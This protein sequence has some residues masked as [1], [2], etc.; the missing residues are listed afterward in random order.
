MSP[1][2]YAI[3]LPFSFFFQILSSIQKSEAT[4]EASQ[5]EKPP[6]EDLEALETR[7]RS[8][9]DR[10]MGNY[11]ERQY[12]RVSTDLPITFQ[13]PRYES[14]DY[15]S[16]KHNQR[17]DPDRRTFFEDFGY[18]PYE[19]R[20]PPHSYPSMSGFYQL[21]SSIFGGGD[22]RKPHPPPDPY[23]FHHHYSKGVHE[24]YPYEFSYNNNYRPTESNIIPPPKPVRASVVKLESVTPEPDIYPALDFTTTAKYYPHFLNL[25]HQVLIENAK[26]HHTNELGFHQS[27]PDPDPYINFRQ[28]PVLDRPKI[29]NKP[30]P[31]PKE[32]IIPTTYKPIA[33]YHP[34][35]NHTRP[36]Y[37]GSIQDQLPPLKPGDDNR[38]PYVSA[39]TIKLPSTTEKSPETTTIIDPRLGATDNIVFPTAEINT[40][41]DVLSDIDIRILNANFNSIPSKIVE[42]PSP[43][44]NP[45]TTTTPKIKYDERTDAILAGEST[46]TYRITVP[47]PKKSSRSKKV[48]PPRLN[49]SVELITDLT[50][51]GLSNRNENVNI[52]RYVNHYNMSNL[53]NYEIDKLRHNQPI[54]PRTQSQEISTTDQSLTETPPPPRHIVDINDELSLDVKILKDT[55]WDG[56]TATDPPTTE[57]EVTQK[58]P[59]TTTIPET[60]TIVVETRV[61]KSVSK[62]VGFSKNHIHQNEV[63]GKDDIAITEPTKF[64]NFD[65]LKENRRKFYNRRPQIRLS[66]DD[67]LREITT[68]ER[69]IPSTEAPTTNIVTT[70]RSTKLYPVITEPEM[71]FTTAMD[72]QKITTENN[73]VDSLKKRMDKPN[74]D[75]S[76]DIAAMITKPTE[77]T[78]NR[79]RKYMRR[80]KI[81][82]FAPYTSSTTERSDSL[83]FG[84][85]SRV[86][87][88]KRQRPNITLSFG[89]RKTVK[90]N[91]NQIKDEIMKFSDE[92][93]KKNENK[94]EIRRNH[95]KR[96]KYPDYSRSRS[97][98][99]TE[100]SVTDKVNEPTNV[101]L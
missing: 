71:T 24:P 66:I 101:N 62:S 33:K 54:E 32:N 4:E 2:N 29:Y 9:G 1:E 95:Y 79:K 43:T 87:F 72:I 80:P 85:I 18:Y 36:K 6:E 57:N 53:I 73:E 47:P 8:R 11:G 94:V 26:N 59:T 67:K 64:R 19:E 38:I 76:F 65:T 98:S 90:S 70:E 89:S 58:T 30:S 10:Y 42:I 86:N 35:N 25:L 3:I 69:Y 56:F 28:K 45:P 75:E 83:K 60:P 48:T 39:T 46:E 34:V 14:K 96:R 41:K 68:T 22:Y 17:G 93:L 91:E 5:N 37:P 100:K 61:T 81:T 52:P 16:S 20:H 88:P 13:A 27:Y 21:M 40:N 12:R 84:K 51:K 31:P 82:S 97:T 78:Y 55:N 99:T 63:S 74:F 7:Y 44:R 77:P 49:D 23:P 50:V 92:D 15:W